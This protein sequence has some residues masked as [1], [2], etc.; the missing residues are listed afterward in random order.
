MDRLPARL[1]AGRLAGDPG[2]SN[3]DSESDSD[4]IQWRLTG[5]LSSSFKFP[6]PGR[7]PSVPGPVASEQESRR[8]PL[9]QWRA[10]GP[11]RL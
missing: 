4:N 8:S 7:S 5:K 3:S 1:G 9:P 6:P 2:F 11:T 10:S